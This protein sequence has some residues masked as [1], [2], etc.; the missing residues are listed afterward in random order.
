MALAPWGRGDRLGCRVALDSF[1]FHGR[2]LCCSD[3]VS[4]PLLPPGF[5]DGQWPVLAG[6]TAEELVCAGF[7]FPLLLLFL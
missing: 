4:Q 6:V 7:L 3:P 2:L 5:S 1:H